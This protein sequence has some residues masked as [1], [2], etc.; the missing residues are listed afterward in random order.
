[1]VYILFK[2]Q[3]KEFNSHSV[4]TSL[5]TENTEEHQKN[6]IMVIS[7]IKSDGE[8][9]IAQFVLSKG[10]KVHNLQDPIFQVCI[11]SFLF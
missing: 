2:K 3:A 5:L 1:M 7:A 10:Q 9:R 11:T 8:K 4:H 6:E